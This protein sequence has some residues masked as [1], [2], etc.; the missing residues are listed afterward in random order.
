MTKSARKITIEDLE[1][2]KKNQQKIVCLT[3]YTAPIAKIIDPISDII[4]VGD[5]LA[6]TIY[7][8]SNTRQI[9]LATMIEHGKA[10]SKFANHS[11]VVVDLPFNSYEN[12]QEQALASA[13]L[14]ISQCQCDAIK[15]ETSPAL[16]PTVKHL[17]DNNIKVMAHIGLLPQTVENSQDFRYQGRNHDSA[18]EILQTALALEKAGAFAIVIEAVPEQLASKISQQLSIPTIGIGASKDCDG[19]VLVID[20]VLGINPDFCPK[21]VHKYFDLHKAISNAVNDFASDVRTQKFPF[22]KNLLKS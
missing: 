17:V 14:V 21:F 4:L 20:D 6:M 9:S 1:N 2:F 12:S 3:A 11:L 18:E 7:G 16:V 13:H 19:Q 10:V 22:D 8:H 5:S 15:I